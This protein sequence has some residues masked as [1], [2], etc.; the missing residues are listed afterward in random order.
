MLAL[1][2]YLE[3]VVALRVHS[4]ADMNKDPGVVFAAANLKSWETA[5]GRVQPT[6]LGRRTAGLDRVDDLPPPSLERS[7]MA[8]TERS[9]STPTAAVGRPGPRVESQLPGAAA[10]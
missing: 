5:L 10:N 8:G 1:S 9:Q 6:D 7:L 3:V 2:A 4:K